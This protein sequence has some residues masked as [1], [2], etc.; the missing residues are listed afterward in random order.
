MRLLLFL[1]GLPLSLAAAPAFDQC[2]DFG[3]RTISHNQ[4]SES[5]WQQVLQLFASVDSAAQE[6]QAIRQAIALLESINGKL[7]GTELDKAGNYPGSDIAHQMDCIDESTNTSQYLQALQQAGVLRWHT[8][9]ER[10]LRV[11]FIF[12][13]WTAVIRETANGQLY[14]V[15]SWYR[16]NGEPPYL[17]KLEDWRRKRDFPKAL[18]P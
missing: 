11:R 1:L 17:Q 7:S 8:V 16:D 18:N 2:Y 6:K 5:D 12:S 4:L 15:D 9:V 14:A 13:H 10:E 3:C